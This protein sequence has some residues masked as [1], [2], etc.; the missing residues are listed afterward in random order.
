MTSG[1]SAWNILGNETLGTNYQIRIRSNTQTSVFDFLDGNFEITGGASM[2]VTSPNGGERRA[3]DSAQN[4]TWNSSCIV[5]DVQIRLFRGGSVHRT[6]APATAN[7]GSFT[8]N[9]DPAE[10]LD[11]TYQSRVRSN[12]VHTIFDFSDADFEVAAP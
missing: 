10:M 5:G 2:T 11:T 3:A 6:L 9:I 7:D 4:V 1:S 12:S 8:W